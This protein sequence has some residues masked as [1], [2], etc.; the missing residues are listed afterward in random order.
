[1]SKRGGGL[2]GH[3]G[4]RSVDTH[5]GKEFRRIRVGIGHPGD[6]DQVH[7]YV[8]ND[9]AKSELAMFEKV[10]DAIA[11]GAEFLGAR[12]YDAFMT[13]VSLFLK[14]PR[15]KPEKKPAPAATAKS[16]AES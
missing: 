10:I 1:M 14:P 3:N 6:K 13:K 4:L 2:A 7:G 15:P 12:E 8:L 11:D 5:I 9:F 16:T